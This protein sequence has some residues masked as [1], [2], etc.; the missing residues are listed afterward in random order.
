MKPAVA[1]LSSAVMLALSADRLRAP[2]FEETPPPKDSQPIAVSQASPPRKVLGRIYFAQE[3]P[4]QVRFAIDGKELPVARISTNV[5]YNTNTNEETKRWRVDFGTV[6]AE[7]SSSPA[8][9]FSANLFPAPNK[10]TL[11]SKESLFN[12]FRTPPP[13]KQI[14]ITLPCNLEI[15]A[16]GYIKTTIRL[17]KEEDLLRDNVVNFV[18]QKP[19][20]ATA[21]SQQS[22]APTRP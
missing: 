6:S 21:T 22:M 5:S 14:E 8:E 16:P 3:L 9:V 7:S 15:S 10:R 4:K 12:P 11:S 1:S 13:I 17:S 2:I 18:R 20:S 19:E